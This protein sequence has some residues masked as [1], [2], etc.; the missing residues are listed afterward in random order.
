MLQLTRFL[1]KVGFRGPGSLGTSVQSFLPG[2]DSV[3]FY[4]PDPALKRRAIVGASPAGLG[5]DS[6]G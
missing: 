1:R 3:R 4:F 5:V 2:R 6:W